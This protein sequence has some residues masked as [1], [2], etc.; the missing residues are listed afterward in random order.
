MGAHARERITRDFDLKTT[1]DAY[2]AA[3]RELV[4]S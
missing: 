2:V 4:A 1:A 3:Y